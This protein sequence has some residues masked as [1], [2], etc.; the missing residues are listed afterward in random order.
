MFGAI[1][2]LIILPLMIIGTSVVLYYISGKQEEIDT[3]RIR[4]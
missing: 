3:Q 1:F 4:R 2:A